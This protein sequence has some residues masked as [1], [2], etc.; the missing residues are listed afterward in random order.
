MTD[1]SRQANPFVILATTTQL[2]QFNGK[3]WRPREPATDIACSIHGGQTWPG[4]GAGTVIGDGDSLTVTP[5]GDRSRLLRT[6]VLTRP[7]APRLLHCGNH[8]TQR[9]DRVGRREHSAGRAGA[10]GAGRDDG[11][12]ILGRADARAVEDQNVAIDPPNGGDRG[13]DELLVSWPRD[14]CRRSDRAARP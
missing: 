12:R 14:R 1:H 5:I 11:R 9:L 2:G 3:S 6:V 4:S 13:G 8:R 10:V 7:R